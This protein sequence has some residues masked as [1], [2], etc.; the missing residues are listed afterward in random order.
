MRFK[1]FLKE[2]IQPSEEEIPSIL[3]HGSNYDFSKFDLAHIGKGE[4]MQKF[5]YGVYLTN[6]KKLAKFYATQLKGTQILYEC[7]IP[8]DSRLY[9]WDSIVD[10]YLFNKVHNYLIK[11]D[12]EEDAERIQKE[13]EDYDEYMEFEAYYRI[14]SHLFGGDKQASKI[15]NDLNIDGCVANDRHNRGKIFVIFDPTNIKILEKSEPNVGED[16]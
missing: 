1:Q 12:F 6:T 8:K 15:F 2:N 5:G 3:Y 10:E 11:H 13:F 14:V 4:G 7:R 9:E 16:E